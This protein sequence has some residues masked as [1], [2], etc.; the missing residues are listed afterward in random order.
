MNINLIGLRGV[1]KSNIARRL[2]VLTKR[3]V[4]STDTLIEY[5]SGMPLVDFVAAR[6]WPAF[7]DL[8][9]EIVAKLARLDGLIVDCGG[10]VII[11]LDDEGLEVFSTRKVAALRAGGPIVFLEGDIARL[12]AKVADDPTRPSLDAARSAEAVMRARAPLYRQAADT[13]L[14]VE[15]ESRPQVAWA[16][17]RRVEDGTLA[18]R[19]G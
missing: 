12:A 13:T 5:E 14:F 15:R 6:G 18:Y 8:E 3:P 10:G 16:I 17:A 9:Y 4:M 19:S 1:G 11:D 7:R 2:S